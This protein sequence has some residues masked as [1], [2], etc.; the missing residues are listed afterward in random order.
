MKRYMSTAL[1]V[2]MSAVLLMSGCGTAVYAGD[3][4]QE[5]AERTARAFAL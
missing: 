3:T 4:E 1:A 2:T 5:T